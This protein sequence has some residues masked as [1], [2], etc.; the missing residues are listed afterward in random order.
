M[1][2][3]AA[4]H[5]SSYGVVSVLSSS[6]QIKLST[7]QCR[8]CGSIPVPRP[9]H[10]TLPPQPP[11]PLSPVLCPDAAV[12]SKTPSTFAGD[13]FAPLLALFQ[14]SKDLVIFSIRRHSAIPVG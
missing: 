13:L 3:E 6:L 4:I 7:H 2:S 5:L 9:C 1:T 11:G 12:P 14:G 8:P 10:V